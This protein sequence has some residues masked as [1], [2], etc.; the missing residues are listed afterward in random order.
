MINKINNNMG[1]FKNN[2]WASLIAL[3]LTGKVSMGKLLEKASTDEM[4]CE[5]YAFIGFDFLFKENKDQAKV[6]FNKCINT[7]IEYYAEYFAKD[8]LNNL[9]K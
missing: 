5:A 8:E 7:N 2:D 1:Y 6:Y 3:F 9:L 4:K